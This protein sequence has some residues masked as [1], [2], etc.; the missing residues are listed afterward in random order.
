ML[1]KNHYNRFCTASKLAAI[2]VQPETFNS[3]PETR[4]W[5]R[6]Q[7]QTLN[8]KL[9]PPRQIHYKRILLR[10]FLVDFKPS[11]S[12]TVACFHVGAQV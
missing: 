9:F 1:H 8:L 11:S 3:K 7:P 5:T 2:D 6:A 10:G 4:N 12:S